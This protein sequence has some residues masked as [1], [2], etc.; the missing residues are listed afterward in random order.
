MCF[1]CFYG[2]VSQSLFWRSLSGLGEVW[3]VTEYKSH[4]FFVISSVIQWIT[5][6]SQLMKSNR[7]SCKHLSFTNI[8]FSSLN[9]SKHANKMKFVHSAFPVG[10]IKSPLHKQWDRHVGCRFFWVTFVAAQRPHGRLCS[11]NTRGALA[12]NVQLPFSTWIQI[13]KTLHYP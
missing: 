13:N 11:C 9:N 2:S 1:P 6:K 5:K 4:G 7:P 12:Q 10:Q 8:L 3:N